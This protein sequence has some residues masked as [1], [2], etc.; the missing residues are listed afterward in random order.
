MRSSS[1]GLGFQLRPDDVTATGAF[2]SKPLADLEAA[3]FTSAD[4]PAPAAASAPASQPDLE[5]L[6]NAA[7]EEG[8]EAGRAELP[9]QEA[10]QLETAIVA[11]ESA[12]R[13]FAAERRDYLR[14]QRRALVELAIA[15]AERILMR[16]LRAD[17]AALVALVE[18]AIDALP[19]ASRDEGVAL[20]LA[21]SDHDAL[22]H[23]EGDAVARLAQGGA[24]RIVSDPDLAPGDARVRA[25]ATTLDARRAVLLER[26]REALAPAV[27]AAA[28]PLPPAATAEEPA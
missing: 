3:R 28:T 4:A 15:I 2:V 10:R 6:R 20:H 27:D 12:E 9:W 14:A 25:G 13:A 5:A 24:V 16:E 17:P 21:P 1:D 18:R 19:E 8:R 11:L 26:V 23:G 22:A 7:F